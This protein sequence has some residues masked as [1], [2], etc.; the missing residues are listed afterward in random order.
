MSFLRE[1][2]DFAMRGN[3]FDLAVA[4]VL[5]GAF[6]RIVTALV[7][8]V[9]MPVIGVLVSDVDFSDLALVLQE[10][11]G[12]KP[13]VLVKYG[14]F[15]QAIVNFTIIA[16]VIFLAIRGM[17]ALQRKEEAKPTP[18]PEPSAEVKLL[19]EIRDALRAR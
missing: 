12:D 17:K 8:G 11:D 18:A 7:E 19:T 14:A 16:F 2:R 9:L 10:A 13:A 1:F 3:V 5:G 6:G 15:L 4:V